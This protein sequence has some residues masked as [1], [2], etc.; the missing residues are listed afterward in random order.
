IVETLTRASRALLGTADA[1]VAADA[2]FTDL[3]GDSLSALTF[4]NLLH[5]IFGVGVPVSVIIGSTT[6]L[7]G[8]AEYIEDQRASDVDRPTVASVHGPGATEVRATDLTLDKFIDETTLTSAPW[9]L[10]ATGTPK[11]VLLTGASGWLGRFLALE[12]LDRLAGTGGT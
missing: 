6:T 12:W 1:D 10:P 11:T 2:R 9:L 3:G 5:E 7:A 8:L 4:S